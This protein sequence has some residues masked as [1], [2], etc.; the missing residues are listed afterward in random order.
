MIAALLATTVV[1][2]GALCGFGWYLI[3]Q[4]RGLDEHRVQQQLEAGADAAVARLRG[5]LAETGEHLSGAVAAGSLAA[6]PDQGEAVAIIASDRVSVS[7]PGSLPFV[8]AVPASTDSSDAFTSVEQLEFARGDFTAAAVRYRA[9]A[10]RVDP[11]VRAG[12]WL[13]LGRVLRRSRDFSGALA[14]YRELA[15]LGT[16]RVGGLPAELAALEA[17]VPRFRP[18]E[19]A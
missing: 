11:V 13:R 9:L 15:E 16:V 5:K 18:W 2:T 4:Q 10:R 7:P 19:T 17:S 1:V 3:D 8:P 12:A 14:A 6:P